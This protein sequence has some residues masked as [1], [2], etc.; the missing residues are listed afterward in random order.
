MLFF[1]SEN[2]YFCMDMA[3]IK[4]TYRTIE[5]LS[6]GIYKEKGSRFIAFAIP[7]KTVDEIKSH[8]EA[9]RKKYYDA[10]HVCY[11]YRVG[12]ENEEY[13]YNDDGEP[14]GTAGKPIYG[15]I[16]SK[17]L[18]DVLIVVVRYFGGVKLGTGGLAVAYKEAAAD[19]LNNNVVVEKN[20]QAV[21]RVAFSYENMNAVLQFIKAENIEVTDR[22]FDAS[23]SMTC[24]VPKAKN[25]LFLAKMK[26]IAKI[27]Q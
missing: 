22:N 23:C 16:L 4:D 24:F 25:A 3:E 11:A 27:E 18:T 5:V 6:E 14:S 20:I 9:Y 17:E 2:I 7:V 10:R 21:Y 15:Q 1:I 12:T 19:A 8:L 13:R 26:E